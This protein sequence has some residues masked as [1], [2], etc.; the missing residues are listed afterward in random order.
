[1]KFS[2]ILLFLII[3]FISLA[4]ADVIVTHE[5]Y[6]GIIQEDGTLTKTTNKIEDFKTEVYSCFDYNCQILSDKLDFSTSYLNN[7]VSI[8]FPTQ[9]ITS[10][11]YVLYFLKEGRIGWEKYNFK[12]SGDGEGDG[13][14]AYL[15]RKKIGYAPIQDLNVL[16]EVH[17]GIP[18]EINFTVGIDADTYS[19]LNGNI[20]SGLNIQETVKTEVTLQIFDNLDNLEYSEVKILQIPYSGVE[21]VEFDYIFDRLGLKEIKLTT[22]VLDDKLIISLPQSTTA[23]VKVIEQGKKNYS[24]TIL[25]GFEVIPLHPTINTS[26][27]FNIDYLSNYLD[28]FGIVSPVNTTLNIS[29]I[30]DG[31]ILNSSLVEFSSAGTYIFDY[32]F[33]SEG[34]WEVIVEGLPDPLLGD[35]VKDS[36]TLNFYVF[37]N[38]TTSNSSLD[39]FAFIENLD[40]TKTSL[41]EG[42]LYGFMFDYRF[43]EIT[44]LGVESFING[45]LEVEILLENSI[46]EIINFNLSNNGSFYYEFE[47]EEGKYNVDLTLCPLVNSSKQGHCQTRSLVFEVEDENSNDGSSSNSKRNYDD[48]SGFEFGPSISIN[49]GYEGINLNNPSEQGV[50]VVVYL[51]LLLLSLCLIILTGIV[52]IL[53]SRR[54]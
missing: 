53:W 51:I 41:E 45:T 12:V 15:S 9:M 31:T 24:Y 13:A 30:L 27:S 1:M 47:V 46:E 37:D 35:F 18:L 25:N 20:Y 43:L 42:D 16:N 17:P 14:P 44:N 5:V 33:T 29:Y 6:E 50:P 3:S 49:S 21:E 2:F 39:Y 48:D 28:E 32:N 23:K 22:R 38:F 34:Y 19:A 26:S 10:H 8:K 11:G 36:R 4:S 54:R 40:H 52:M 7:T